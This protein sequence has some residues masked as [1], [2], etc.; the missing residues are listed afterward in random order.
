MLEFDIFANYYLGF[1]EI[2]HFISKSL[3]FVIYNK[4]MEFYMDWAEFK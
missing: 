1:E 2:D 3:H 4:N